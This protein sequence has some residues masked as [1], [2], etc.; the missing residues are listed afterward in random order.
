MFINAIAVCPVDKRLNVSLLNE[1]KV[2][3]PPQ[4]PTISNGWTHVN[5]PCLFAKNKTKI[6]KIT[7]DRI[8]EIKVPI[9][10]FIV[11]N[12]AVVFETRNLAKLPN[13]PPIKM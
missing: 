13:P 12:E 2:L 11:K 8:F 3:N 5:S 6:A 10:K 7:H 1:E 9:G 4:N